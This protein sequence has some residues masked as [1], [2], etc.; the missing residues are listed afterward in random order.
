MI[1]A[2]FHRHDETSCLPCIGCM[3]FF[4]M[5]MRKSIQRFRLKIEIELLEKDKP[6]VKSIF[7]SKTKRYT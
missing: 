4:I 2:G 5:R 3:T 6:E 1:K 7:H